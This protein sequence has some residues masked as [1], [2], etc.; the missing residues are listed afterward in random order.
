MAESQ[1]SPVGSDPT[2]LEWIQERWETVWRNITRKAVAPVPE[3]NP[4]PGINLTP[5]REI[6]PSIETITDDAQMPIMPPVDQAGEA[7]AKVSLNVEVPVGSRLVITISALKG[8]SAQ[9]TQHWETQPGSDLEPAQSAPDFKRSIRQVFQ[10]ATRLLER[11]NFGKQISVPTLCFVAA[12]CIYLLTRLW[13][14]EAFPI[15][16]FGD[17][18]VQTLYAEKLIQNGFR[19]ANGQ[20]IPIYVEAAGMRWTPLF[21]MYIQAVSLLLFGKSIIVTR[22]TSAIVSILAALSIA[23]ILKL[24]FKSRYWWTGVLFLVI[25][26]AWFLHSRTA[27]EAVMMTAFYGCCLLFYLLYRTKSPRYL[28]P[29]LVFGAMTFYTYSNAQAIIALT[30]VLLLLSDIRYHVNNWRVLFVGLLILVIL[31]LPFINFEIKRPSAM[32]QHLRAVNS[33][34]FQ[35]IPLNEK[36]SYFIKTYSYGLSPAYWFFP[37]EKDIIR[38]RWDTVG[39]MWLAILPLLLIGLAICLKNIR[40][41]VHRVVL[42]SILAGPAGAALLDVHIFRVL[43]LV[44][45]WTILTSLGLEWVLE[46]LRKRFSRLSIAAVSTVSLLILGVTGFWM[47]YS[48][49]VKGP[50][51]FNIYGLYGMQ[52]GAKQ[53][54]NEAI[55]EILNQDHQVQIIVSST[56]ANG[57]DNF[58]QFFIPPR[59]RNRVQMGGIEGYLYERL[60]LSNQML[61]VLTPSEEDKAANSIKFKPPNIERIINYPD[62]SPGFYFVRLA[63]VDQV[64]DIF[65]AEA[66]AR[67][68]LAE[69]TV[70]V[71]GQELRVRFSQIDAGQLR[72]LFDGDRFTLMRGLEANPFILEFTFSQPRALS[73]IA[74]DF[75]SMDFTFSFKLF[76]P[77]AQEP[78]EYTQTFRKLPADPHVEVAFDNAPPLVSKVIIEIKSLNDGQRAHIHIRELK[79]LP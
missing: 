9:V 38:H 74:A 48:G 70:V 79:F 50:T 17:E 11:L 43:T 73:G 27:F 35:A 76:A 54:F 71:D 30:A 34:W 37:N 14:L 22:A 23:L 33:Y 47:L 4:E 65:A 16:F 69:G 63:Y 52:Y 59:L 46:S 68:Q 49:L 78:V 26:P 25:T 21:P 61:F 58:V 39:H 15:Y 12:V 18:A 20:S 45:P 28:Y 56:W 60:P 24:V 66:E 41:S 64:D 2:I 10:P 57:T 19:D 53:V 13:S 1:Q 3:A 8:Q 75:G 67:R 40:S 32:S 36:L 31:A 55:P 77:E 7:S 29:C 62:G 72:D 6:V 5:E 44:I 42:I 51:W